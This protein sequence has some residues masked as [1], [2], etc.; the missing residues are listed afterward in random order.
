MSKP[1][2][3][4]NLVDDFFLILNLLGLSCFSS[5]LLLL[6]AVTYIRY[7]TVIWKP[8]GGGTLILA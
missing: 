6:Y 2:R 8:T 4:F 7:V 3:F 5:F 1:S